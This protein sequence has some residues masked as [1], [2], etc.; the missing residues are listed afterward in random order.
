MQNAKQY[1]KF[2]FDENS[3]VLASK[4]NKENEKGQIFEN[5]KI[6]TDYNVEEMVL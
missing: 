6:Y 5:D 3:Y 2:P 1:L 4:T